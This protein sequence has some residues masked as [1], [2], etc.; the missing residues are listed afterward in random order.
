MTALIFSFD[1]ED[2]VNPHAAEGI[3]RASKTVREGG[4]LPC[5]NV[6]AKLAENL[7]KWGRQDVIDELKQCEL[8]THSLAHSMHPTINEYTDIEDFEEAMRRFRAHE[9]EAVRILHEV[10]GEKTIIAGCPPGM[11]VS[12]VA[13]YG[14][15]DMG[16]PIYDGSMV[17]DIP[18]GRP[19]SYCNML[20]LEYHQCLDDLAECTKDEIDRRID[21]LA[22][23]EVAVVYHHPAKNAVLQFCDEQ[24]FKG[25]NRPEAEWIMAD[26]SSP[27]RIAKFEENLRYF[28]SRVRDDDRFCGSTY[29]EVAEKY[30][31]R[32]RVHRSDI[33]ALREA[34]TEE[35]FPVT[36]P[37]SLAVSDILLSCRDFLLGKDVHDCQKI[38]GFLSAPYAITEPVC[39]TANELRLAAAQIPDG[40]FLPTSIDVGEKTLGPA[41]FLRAS[42]DIL[43]G[44]EKTTVMPG[45]WQIDLDEFPKLRDLRLAGTWIHSPAFEDRYITD[46]M[47]LQ[48]WTIRL[49]KG[50][51]RKIF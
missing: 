35:L 47:R 4:F 10:L 30:S 48:S 22:T 28:V 21:R 39:V 42:L 45:S 1:T 17:Y 27:E 16:I 38:Y 36:M 15:A 37:E 49:P 43:S 46:R 11:S 25:E 19:L 8:A 24:N 6:V 44:C 34:I 2:Y 18:R 50:T 23:F 5:H 3:L 31:S 29:G 7:V 20:H 12:Y 40:K 13:S 51:K 14:Y 26:P 33:P 41:D 32:R 9:D